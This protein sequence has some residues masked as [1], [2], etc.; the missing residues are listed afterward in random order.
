MTKTVSWP[1]YGRAIQSKLVDSLPINILYTLESNTSGTSILLFVYFR[2]FRLD[3]LSSEG[4]L[5]T[6]EDTLILR[7]QVRPPT[8]YQK[9]RDQQW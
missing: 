3:L 4:Y 7:F 2:F 9:C 8:F 6:D 5:N 1:W